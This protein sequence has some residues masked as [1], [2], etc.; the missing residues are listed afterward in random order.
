[1]GKTRRRCFESRRGRSSPLRRLTHRSTKVS[2][3]QSLYDKALKI[4]K[5]L[6]FQIDSKVV[7]RWRSQGAVCAPIEL[8]PY[9]RLQ[10]KQTCRNITQRVLF[11]SPR[12]CAAASPP[13]RWEKREKKWREVTVRNP[14]PRVFFLRKKSK[15]RGADADHGGVVATGRCVLL[16]RERLVFARGRVR[17]GVRERGA[18]AAR[19]GLARAPPL[20]AARGASCEKRST[21]R[22]V[23]EKRRL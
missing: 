19:V 14:V 10:M 11:P 3:P 22:V 17:A 20:E 16:E 23:R 2:T 18:A 7:G 1:M 4:P 15:R 12:T 21:Q 13:H 8:E 6:H 5:G 9:L